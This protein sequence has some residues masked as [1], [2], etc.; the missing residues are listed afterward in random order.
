MADA[1]HNCNDSSRM[2]IA[3]QSELEVP[4]IKKLRSAKL[5]EVFD[6]GDMLLFVAADRLGLD[7]EAHSH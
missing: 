6:P 5:C 7:G 4:G 1:I 2:E 3:S